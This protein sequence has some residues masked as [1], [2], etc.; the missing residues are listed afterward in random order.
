MDQHAREIIRCRGTR[1]KRNERGISRHGS[2]GFY[3]AGALFFFRTELLRE[4]DR[5]EKDTREESPA[6]IPAVPISQKEA[7]SQKELKIN[8][9]R[10]CLNSPGGGRFAHLD[11]IRD[12]STGK[13]R[14]GV[15]LT[16]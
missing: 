3:D 4:G 13:A 7:E 1:V 2:Q 16:A 15:S 5:Q 11:A 10:N 14:K 12:D 8:D 6:I 9:S